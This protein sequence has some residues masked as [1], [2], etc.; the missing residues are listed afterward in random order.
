MSFVLGGIIMLLF[1]QPILS[2]FLS[3]FVL[4]DTSST[5]RVVLW[6]EAI[7]NIK[8]RPLLGTGLGNYIL[9]VNPAEDYRTPYYAHNLYLDVATE[10]GLVGLFFF[11]LILFIPLFFSVRNYTQTKNFFS[12][13]LSAALVLYLTHSFFETALYSVHILPLLLFVLSLALLSNENE[14]KEKI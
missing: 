6:R 13:S 11:L 1:G 4:E 10:L 9:A 8:E 12:L 7:E 14:Q 3:S 5:A 2:R